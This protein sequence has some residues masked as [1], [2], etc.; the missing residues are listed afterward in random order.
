MHIQ[1]IRNAFAQTRESHINRLFEL[2]RIPSISAGTKHADDC[3]QCADHL[4]QHTTEMGFT[5]TIHDTSRHPV[6]IA[7]RAGAVNAPRILIYGHYDVQPVDP[8]DA[9]QQPPFQPKIE[10]GRILAR[11][12][13]DNKGQLSYVLAAIEDAVE[14]NT[15]LPTI[16]LLIEVQ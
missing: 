4:L 15:P 10:N 1:N 13:Q 12:A 9:W 11:G 16:T 6:L 14:N 2:L 3:R 7:H 5:G 8:V